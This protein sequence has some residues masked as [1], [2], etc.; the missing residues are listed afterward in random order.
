VR[1]ESSNATRQVLG[2]LTNCEGRTN[3]DGKFKGIK[4]AATVHP[5]VSDAVGLCKEGSIAPSKLPEAQSKLI[6]D[7]DAH[8]IEPVGAR[9]EATIAREKLSDAIGFA[10]PTKRYGDIANECGEG[11][12]IEMRASPPAWPVQSPSSKLKVCEDRAASLPPTPREALPH[13]EMSNVM[14][15][16]PAL[17]KVPTN[18]TERINQQRS[19][20]CPSLGRKE[21]TKIKFAEQL[22]EASS[23][24]KWYMDWLANDECGLSGRRERKVQP[25][26][27]REL[28]PRRVHEPREVR[29]SKIEHSRWR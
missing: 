29:E 19:L 20:S 12:T 8:V 3:P 1:I 25:V 15:V 24:P 14:H 2:D 26:K 17:R 7:L 5:K 10:T 4:E 23:P 27:L 6:V 13:P 22:Q 28:S 21:D 9:K 18:F 11:K 16:K